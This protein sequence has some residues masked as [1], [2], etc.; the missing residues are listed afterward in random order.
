MTKFEQAVLQKCATA[1]RYVS[2]DLVE[3]RALVR[4][5]A[6][7]LCWKT[8]GVPVFIVSTDGVARLAGLGL[9]PERKEP[10]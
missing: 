1:G 10:T 5:V 8:A 3:T 2:R 7:G 6:K 9:L 4:L